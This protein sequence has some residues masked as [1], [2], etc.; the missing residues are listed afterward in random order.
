MTEQKKPLSISA[1]IKATA[2]ALID[3]AAC[4]FMVASSSPLFA[5]IVMLLAEV[6][7]IALAV[8]EWV[9][10]FRAYVARQI[11]EHAGLL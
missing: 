7:L 6:A 8:R 5:L 11:E 10:Y 2:L 3:F 4:F 9:V 1:P